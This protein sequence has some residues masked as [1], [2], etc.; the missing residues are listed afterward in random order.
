MR[1]M[2]FAAFAAL[3]A[4]PAFAQQATL[5]TPSGQIVPGVVLYCANG[6]TNADGSAQAVPCRPETISVPI[7]VQG[8]DQV[9]T[10]PAG[11]LPSAGPPMF[12]RTPNFT[13]LPAASVGRV[14]SPW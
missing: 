11:P 14:G 8:T 3:F 7:Q 4:M 12:G 5:R 10:S 9:A 13:P 1:R 2:S 6:I